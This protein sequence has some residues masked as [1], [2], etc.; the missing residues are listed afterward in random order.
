M[1]NPQGV[2]LEAEA[3]ITLI[4]LLSIQNKTSCLRLWVLFLFFT[5]FLGYARNRRVQKQT[6]L[7]NPAILDVGM[8]AGRFNVPE[9]QSRLSPGLLTR[10]L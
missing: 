1:N 2:W 4:I 9:H 8:E 10:S 6:P 7:R 5:A 3:S